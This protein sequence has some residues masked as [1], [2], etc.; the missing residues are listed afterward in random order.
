MFRS[1]WDHHQTVLYN[2]IRLIKLSIWIR[3]LVQ[4]VHIVK[5]IKSNKSYPS[6]RS[7]VLCCEYDENYVIK[8]LKY[9]KLYKGIVF[10]MLVDIIILKVINMLKDTI[11]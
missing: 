10:K 4:R 3:I 5:F 7:C 2:T 1:S 9:Q 11:Y 6:S 8:I